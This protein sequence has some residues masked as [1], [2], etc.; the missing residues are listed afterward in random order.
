M[1]RLIFDEMLRRTATWCRIF[2][3]DS[4]YVRDVPDSEILKIAEDENRVLVTR[5][6]K[7]AE[8][9]RTK[10]VL[11]K[12][13]RLEDQLNQLKSELGG[14]FT[15]PEKTRCPACNGRLEIV[16]KEKVKDRVVDNVYKQNEKFW[17]C[18]E[19]G[20]VYWEGSHWKNI[21]RIFKNIK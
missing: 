11:L 16:D 19:C 13:D 14:I 3:V 18:E 8:L 9:C 4:R 20:K 21:T 7:L 5:D 2:G 1:V 10:V 17:E 12:N 6:E 15:F